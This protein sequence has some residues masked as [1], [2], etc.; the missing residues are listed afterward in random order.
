MHVSASFLTAGHTASLGER[1]VHLLAAAPGTSGEPL[2]ATCG[3]QA[4]HDKR[5]GRRGRRR[6]EDCDNDRDYY[7][8]DCNAG[9][10]RRCL[11]EEKNF[12]RAHS[13]RSVFGSDY[14]LVFFI[15]GT[16]GKLSLQG[17]TKEA[18]L[19]SHGPQP[20]RAQTSA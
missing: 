17:E 1:Y 6:G 11:I 20:P 9:R 4:N 16:I 7:D 5:Y 15:L 18:S 19:M 3:E 2:R 12:L 10:S 8:E 14:V 13:S